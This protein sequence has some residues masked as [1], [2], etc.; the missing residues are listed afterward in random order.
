MKLAYTLLYVDDVKQSMAFY[1]S[2]FDLQPGF[3]HESGQYGEMQTGDTRL[4]F[5]HHDTAGSHGFSYQKL[6]PESEVPG[7]EIGF[8]TTDVAAAFDKAVSA[9]AVPI[10]QPDTKP[11]GQVVSYVRDL[12]GFLVEICSPMG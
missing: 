5:V 3:L 9:G 10:S 11:W 12:N 2:A 6:G 1:Q 4:G 8:T 7:F